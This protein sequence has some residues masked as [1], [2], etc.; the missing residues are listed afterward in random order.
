MKPTSH[1]SY[2]VNSVGR[3]W[4]I[5]SLTATPISPVIPVYQVRGKQGDFASH[6]GLVPDYGVGFVILGM[7]EEGGGVEL[8]AYADVVAGEM[9]SALE[10]NAVSEAGRKFAGRYTF[11]GEGRNGTVVVGGKRDASPGLEVETFVVAGVDVR[12]L[13]AKKKGMGEGNLS[14]RLYPVDVG[15]GYE[16]GAEMVFRASFQ[17]ETALVDA[18]TPT[19]E[20]W[21]YIDEIQVGGKSLDE[22]VFEMGREGAVAVVVPALGVRLVRESEGRM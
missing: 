15:N 13:I 20:T 22:F 4:E 12:D 8:N 18:G 21:R 14:F 1:T 5:Y 16:E 2:L 19:C 10:K 9:V 17:D 3:P 7:D 6:V 11:G